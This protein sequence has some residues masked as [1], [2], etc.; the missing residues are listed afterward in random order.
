MDAWA[1]FGMLSGAFT[2]LIALVSL[3]V[4]ARNRFD[5]WCQD[6]GAS[7]TIMPDRWSD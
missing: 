3:A 6:L 7:I 1:Y 5:R 2:L 4:D